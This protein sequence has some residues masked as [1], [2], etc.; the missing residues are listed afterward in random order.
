MSART[1][2]DSFLGTAANTRKKLSGVTMIVVVVAII[3]SIMVIHTRNLC[4]Q[5]NDTKKFKDDSWW[6][7]WGAIILLVLSLMLFLYDIAVM[8]KFF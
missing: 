3:L 4:V 5:D 1:G 7:Y 8:T 6:M 2:L